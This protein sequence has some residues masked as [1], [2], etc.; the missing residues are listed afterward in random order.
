[1]TMERFPIRSYSDVLA[2]RRTVRVVGAQQGLHDAAIENLALAV[3][4]IANNILAHAGRGEV[5]LETVT[6]NGRQGVV[7][8]ARDSGPGIPDVERALD[9]GYSSVGGL[10]LGLP[11]AR[12]LVDEFEIDSVVGKGTTVVLRKWKN[13][14]RRPEAPRGRG[15][16]A[17]RS[18]PGGSSKRG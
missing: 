8:T 4:E 5:V 13:A 2:A 17:R 3:T 10:G 14:Q 12:R 15:C 9:D 18:R 7:V 6:S 16:A 1:M 11:S